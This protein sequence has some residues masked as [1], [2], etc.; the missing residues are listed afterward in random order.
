MSREPWIAHAGEQEPVYRELLDK[1]PN[2]I[3]GL[4]DLHYT[5]E[6]TTYVESYDLGES[7]EDLASAIAAGRVHLYE[8]RQE[9]EET[10]RA[11]GMSWA[12][13]YNDDSIDSER[14]GGFLTLY[15]NFRDPN[16]F[17]DPLDREVATDLDTEYDC[18]SEAEYAAATSDLNQDPG[19]PS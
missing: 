17:D 4:Q 19:S 14:H 13:Y 15:R 18:A 7:F 2:E 6:H 16:P 1:E 12:E 11:T 5:L 8:R 3:R 9:E 10:A